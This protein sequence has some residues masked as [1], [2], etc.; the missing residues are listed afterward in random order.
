[1][2][3]SYMTA[4]TAKG[5]WILI[6]QENGKLQDGSLELV[7]EGRKVADKLNEEVTAVVPGDIAEEQVGLLAQH[8]AEWVLCLEHPALNPYSVEVYS[9]VL[10]DVIEE[11]APSVVL[12][13]GSING[14]DLACRVA[15]QL[16]TGLV[17]SCDRVDV[18]TEGNLVQVKPIYGAKAAA[19]CICPADRPQVATVN[20]DALEL[21][22]PDTGR[23]AEVEKY[24]PDVKPEKPSIQNVGFIKGDPK[25]IDL[26]EADIVVAGGMGFSSQENF[27]L[28]DELADVIGGSVGATRRVVDEEWITLSRQIGLTGKTVRPKLFIACGI[29]GAI[30]HT[31]G[32]KDSKLIVAINTDRNALIFKIADVSVVG[33][34]MQ[35]VPELTGQLREAMVQNSKSSADDIPDAASDSKS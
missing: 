33:D 19:T 22:T 13:M 35:V 21:K 15:A 14:T 10:S 30:Q 23:T 7:G 2:E 32:M 9:Q 3:D 6:E 12:A 18:D 29:S 27:R 28:V 5:V 31:M 20:F 17:T 34:V 11:R 8:G 1:M 16:G 4:D 26:T 24:K 25:A